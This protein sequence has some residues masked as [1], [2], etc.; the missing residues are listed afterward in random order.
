MVLTQRDKVLFEKLLSYAVMTTRQVARTVFP[1]VQLTTVLRRLRKLEKQ[2]YI[3][4]NPGLETYEQAWTLTEKGSTVVSNLPPKWHQSRYLL[5]HD[6]KLTAVRLALESIRAVQ[7]W[8][9]EHE[10]RYR[11]AAKH[12]VERAK[13]RLIPDGIMGV[14]WQGVK[15]SLA[16]ELELHGKNSRRYRHNFYEYRTKENI[17]GV[18]YLTSTPSLAKQIEKLWYIDKRNDARPVFFWSLVDD[19]IEDPANS[20]VHFSGQSQPLT[21]LWMPAHSPAQWVGSR[22]NEQEVKSARVS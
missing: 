19:V 13:D 15:E 10:I 3:R 22:R 16:I 8:V 14:E 7:S 12:G 18:W 4:R 6:T 1:D 5:E 2:M 11:V 20:L 9:P 21:K 17:L